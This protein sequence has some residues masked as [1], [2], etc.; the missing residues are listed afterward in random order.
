MTQWQCNITDEGRDN[1]QQ[2]DP[3]IKKRDIKKLQW[4]TKNFHTPTPLPLSNSW[5]GFFKL[6]VGDWRIVY[7]IDNGLHILTVYAI[8]RRDKIYKK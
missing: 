8:A 3:Q 7:D 5:R 6:R 1:L 2:R 4:L